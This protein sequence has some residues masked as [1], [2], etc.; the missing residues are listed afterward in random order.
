MVE[1]KAR[2]MRRISHCSKPLTSTHAPS[3]SRPCAA[4]AS[5][6]HS[7]QGSRVWQASRL[8][9]RHSHPCLTR[10][11]GPAQI[12]RSPFLHHRS[13]FWSLLSSCPYFKILCPPRSEG[14]S[15]VPE[16]SPRKQSPPEPTLGGVARDG[17]CTQRYAFSDLAHPRHHPHPLH[18]R[19]FKPLLATTCEHIVNARWHC[20]GRAA[21]ERGSRGAS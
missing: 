13:P 8:S 1:E 12:P 16:C 6:H 21:G 20:I 2:G 15:M 17:P 18:L 4:L 11:S 7:H 14:L 19:A 9:L 10:Q 5:R 3:A